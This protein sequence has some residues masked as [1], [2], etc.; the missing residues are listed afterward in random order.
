MYRNLQRL[1]R[2]Y[3]QLIDCEVNYMKAIITSYLYDSKEK[4]VQEL[5]R[6]GIKNFEVVKC[7]EGYS[8]FGCMVDI[9]T[10]DDLR[11][12]ENKLSKVKVDNRWKPYCGLII[13]FKKGIMNIMIYDD[14]IE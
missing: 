6:L 2:I 10:I 1:F 4:L 12:L 7:K 13:Y 9:N 5:K 8:N 3:I 11:K 14:Y